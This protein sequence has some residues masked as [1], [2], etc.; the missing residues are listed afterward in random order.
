MFLEVVA[1]TWLG[2]DPAL[3]HLS[4]EA[5]G[6]T[7]YR[8]GDLGQSSA[9]QHLGPNV[10][11]SEG[12]HRVDYVLSSEYTNP[13]RLIALVQVVDRSV[14]PPVVVTNESWISADISSSPTT[15]S[16]DFQATDDGIYDFQ[17]WVGD[18]ADLTHYS[19]TV[20]NNFVA[21][22]GFEAGIA[23]DAD[24]WI[25]EDYAPSDFAAEGDVDLTTPAGCGMA[26]VA[27]LAARTNT[28]SFTGDR[29]L[30]LQASLDCGT[31]SVGEYRWRAAARLDDFY[32]PKSFPSPHVTFWAR[33][34]GSTACENDVPEGPPDEGCFPF[35]CAGANYDAENT[36]GLLF[37]DGLSNANSRSRVLA[38]SHDPHAGSCF[39]HVTETVDNGVLHH[40]FFDDAA[41]SRTGNDGATWF[42]YTIAI[43]TQY[44]GERIS[45]SVLADHRQNWASF[46]ETNVFID[47]VS[48]T[49][50]TGDPL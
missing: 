1:Q 34:A 48:I 21:N 39:A 18:N 40:A 2:N 26:P 42:R 12:T 50:A 29:A 28:A 36:L 47:D 41:I 10:S 32:V 17:I 24:S 6:T 13:V 44:L 45:L 27:S 8:S 35:V 19:T 25:E 7:W 30:Q 46:G 33:M 43:P 38:E 49:N 23:A 16:L 9:F 20:T 11:L 37:D 3:S 15:N 22:S 31:G 14:S 4:G 5:I